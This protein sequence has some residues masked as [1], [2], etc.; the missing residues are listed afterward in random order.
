MRNIFANE[1]NHQMR[2]REDVVFLTAECGF[3]VVESIEREFPERFYNLGIAEQSLVG[4]AAGISLR[5]LRPVAYTMAM[6]LTMRAYEQIRVDVAY[7]NLPVLLAGVIPGLGY[8]NS[9][10]THHVIED[11]AI[12]RVLPNMTVVYPSCEA[13]VR[14][15]ARQGLTMSGPCYIGLG[16]APGNYQAPY[17][18]ADFQIGKS[19]LVRDGR[20]AAIISY[21]PTLPNAAAAADLL[22][23]DGIHV[24]VINM[25]TIKPLDTEAIRQAVSDCGLILTVEE[26]N[27]I[28]GLGGAV[29]E[30]LAEQSGQKYRFKRIGIPDT[31]GDV[32]GSHGYLQKLYGIDADGIAKQVRECLE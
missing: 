29:A 10:P 7:Q 22:E 19:I 8:G 28:G 32:I 25:H 17:T 13:D 18:E 16:R 20:D 1:I 9:G 26:E 21:G 27:I 5:G 6:F 23:K 4:T 11:A 15:A 2:K 30:Y 14:A 12:M 24:R 3:G 31:Y